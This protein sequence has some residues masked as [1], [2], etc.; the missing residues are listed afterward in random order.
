MKYILLLNLI[1]EVIL[2]CLIPESKGYFF[3]YLQQFNHLAWVG[4]F[5]YIGVLFS[6][7]IIQIIKPLLQTLVANSRRHKL[8]EHSLDKGLEISNREQRIQEDVKLY[9]IN[10][11]IVYSEYFISFFI[12]FYLI[13]YNRN[14][15][16]LIVASLA[17]SAVCIISAYL[18]RKKMIN[19]EKS[20]QVIETLFRDEIRIRRTSQSL[21]QKVLKTNINNSVVRFSYN[22][23]VRIQTGIMTLL[24]FIY[25]LPTYLQKKITLGVMMEQASI[26]E[27]LVVNMTIIVSLFP[28]LMQSRASKERIDELHQKN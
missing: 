5:F 26:F 1:I 27:L 24:P 19:A 4:L 16:L 7:D 11:T 13:L 21:L 28:L 18:F 9:S 6:L 23:C 14:H 8:T 12:V 2:T 20:I 10:S 3:T 22:L 15:L 17:Y 25:L